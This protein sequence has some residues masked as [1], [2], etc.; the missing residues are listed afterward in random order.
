MKEGRVP[1]LFDTFIKV[2]EDADIRKL[3]PNE[4]AELENAV[5]DNPYGK[6]HVR[7]GMDSKNIFGSGAGDI[8]K[9]INAK[10]KGGNEYL[11]AGLV[12]TIKRSTTGAW[13]TIKSSLSGTGRFEYAPIKGGLAITNGYD[14]PFV[15]FGTAFGTT[16]NLRLERPDV[17]AQQ[18]QRCKSTT[19]TGELGA[20]KVYLWCWV[21]VTETGER[22]EPSNP[23][24][25]LRTGSGSVTTTTQK[26]FLFRNVPVPTDSRIISKWLYRTEGSD[27]GLTGEVDEAG[28]IFYLAGKF[29]ATLTDVVDGIAD[30][31]LDF[32][33]ILIFTRTP[34]KANYITRS[35]GRLFLG[36]VTVRQYHYRMHWQRSLN[37]GA[38]DTLNWNGSGIDYENSIY[39]GHPVSV[40]AGGNLDADSWYMWAVTFVNKD[41]LES[42]P[43]YT[44]VTKTSVANKTAT[45]SELFDARVN[46]YERLDKDIV[47]RRYYRTEGHAS[48]FTW[49]EKYFYY[50]TQED[51]EPL[52]IVNRYLPTTYIDDV[53]DTSLDSTKYWYQGA[54]TRDADP[55]Q[56]V[57]FSSAIAFS[58]VDQEAYFVLENIRQ[59]F[60][61]DGDTITGMFDDGN[62]VIIFKQNSIIKLY[63]TGSPDNWYIRKVWE[64]HGCDTPKSLTKIGSTYYFVYR[65]RP[66][67]MVSGQAPQ[68]IGF[69]K[70]TTWNTATVID[71][72]INDEWVIF[73]VQISTSY[74]TLIWDTK[75]E[76]WYQ[77]NWG[78]NE[79]TSVGMKKYDT[80]WTKN[81]FLCSVDGVIFQYLPTDP[82]DDILVDEVQPIITFPAFKI[83]DSTKSKLREVYINT[84]IVGTVT[85]QAYSES[86]GLTPLTFTGGYLIRKQFG[87]TGVSSYWKMQLTGDFTQLNSIKAEL[88]PTGRMING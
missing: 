69:G 66:Y 86:A 11:L 52:D 35:N 42:P 78:A 88:R 75:L 34:E 30:E 70:Q 60:E 77:F 2:N 17:T 62:G 1:V 31:E 22:S 40:S 9:L 79:I 10:D 16:E 87:N 67:K 50:L 6:I 59:I 25:W 54:L 51:Y 82:T 7:G 49:D 65:K 57:T 43:M 15:L 80:F 27:W 47:A 83:D 84:D 85:L 5:L 76:T 29:D 41:G 37:V 46:A 81:L 39:S 68:Y 26:Q 55:A 32:S 74:S 44:N 36:G 64:E 38:G 48:T 56:P 8:H 4:L 13:T 45:L 18:I 71:T 72:T 61:E 53:A 63:H 28:K 23:F 21:Y 19:P 12:S 33:D 73:L 58:Q 20:T 14:E 24:T 3:A